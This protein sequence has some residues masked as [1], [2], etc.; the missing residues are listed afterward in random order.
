MGKEVSG[1]KFL[2]KILHWG[3]WPEFLYEFIF[4]CFT[5]SLPTQLYMSRRSGGIVQEKFSSGVAIVWNIFSLE[6]ISRWRNFPCGSF[7]QEQL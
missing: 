6:E 5:F 4:T 3:N 2:E 1:R 7:P